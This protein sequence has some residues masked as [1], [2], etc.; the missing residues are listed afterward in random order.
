MLPHPPLLQVNILN[1]GAPSGASGGVPCKNT[2]GQ[3]RPPLQMGEFSRADRVVRPYRWCWIFPGAVMWAVREAGP[4]GGGDLCG[5]LMATLTE[6]QCLLRAADGRPYGNIWRR[7]AISLPRSGRWSSTAHVS[8]QTQV[9]DL[10]PPCIM[11]PVLMGHDGCLHF[12]KMPPESVPVKIRHHMDALS[13][14]LGTVARPCPVGSIPA[15]S[16]TL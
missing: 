2:G 3:S 14:A 9:R 13:V 16:S 1:A 5:R 12:C 4:Y 15:A 6:G 7:G 8:A 11:S 10:P